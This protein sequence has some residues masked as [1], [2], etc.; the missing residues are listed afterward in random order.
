MSP[1]EEAVVSPV[2]EAVV[3]DPTVDPVDPAEPANPESPPPS[4]D[5]ASD[6]TKSPE[7]HTQDL[8]HTT[9]ASFSFETST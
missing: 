6:T 4:E 9:K 8:I 2:D 5:A 3:P 7:T 1:A